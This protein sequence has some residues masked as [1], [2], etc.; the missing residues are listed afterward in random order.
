MKNGDGH[1]V[2]ARTDMDT[3]PVQ[4]EYGVPYASKPVAK[5]DEDKEGRVMHACGH[6]AHISMFIGVARTLATIKDQWHGTI[7]LVGQPAEETG[8]GARALLHAG[9]DEKSC[10]PEFALGFHDK[11]DLQ[12]CH[13]GVTEGSTDGNV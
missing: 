10:K 6:D 4:E 5:N 13:I 2:L 11:A 1:K 12:T 7:I 8:Y 9:L 3:L